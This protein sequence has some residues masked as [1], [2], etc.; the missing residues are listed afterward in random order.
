MLFLIS[1]PTGLPGVASAD[2]RKL[3][4]LCTQG[5][6]SPR[7]EPRADCESAEP[8]GDAPSNSR[9]D[10]NVAMQEA[11][12]KDYANHRRISAKIKSAACK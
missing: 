8:P 6:G 4:S 5:W 9:G 11:E 1:S 12:E 2:A 10:C 3:A 7:A